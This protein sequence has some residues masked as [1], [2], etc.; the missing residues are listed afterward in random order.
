MNDKALKEVNRRHIPDRTL[1]R[2]AITLFIVMLLFGC[3][4]YLWY[5]IVTG[6]MRIET[7][8][9]ERNNERRSSALLEAYY[10]KELANV[11]F[12]LEPIEQAEVSE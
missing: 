11:T 12:S 3:G 10:Q 4:H 8:E 5:R 7:L 6:D 2:I 9:L 1:I